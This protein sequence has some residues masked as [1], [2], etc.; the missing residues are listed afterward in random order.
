VT[1]SGEYDITVVDDSGIYITNSVVLNVSTAPCPFYSTNL[2]V[3]RVGDGAQA[4]SGATGNTI[5]LDQYTTSGTYVSSIQIPD[6]SLGAPYGSGSSASVYGSPALLLPGAG[7]DYINSGM[8]TLSGN[9]QF[10]TFAAYCENF[11]FHGPDVTTAANGGPYWRGLALVNAAGQYTLAYTNSGLYTGASSGDSTS[12]SNHSV[13]ACVTIDG[14]DFWTAGQAGSGGGV[15]CLDPNNTVYKNGTGI[16]AISTSSL[17]GTHMVQVFGTNLVYSDALATNGSGLY[18]CAG[19]PV[20][21]ANHFATAKVLLNEGGR[22]NDFAISPDGRTV[23]IADTRPYTNSS[24]HGGGI[25]RWDTN[26]AL[27][28][29]TF[30]YSLPVHGTNG[31]CALTASF[32]ADIA[33]WGSNVL[34]ATLFATDSNSVLSSVVDNGPSSTPTTI[35]NTSPFNQALHGVRFGPIA[36]PLPVISAVSSGNQITLIVRKGQAGVTFRVLST[37]N[38]SSP[39]W[40][41][42]ATNS[43][44]NNGTATNLFDIDPH[45]TQRFYR[46][47]QY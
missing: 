36:A 43:F 29:Y 35:L 11:P 24:T 22:P 18:I 13:R 4:L 1:D 20:P 25:Q 14:L 17:T 9:R 31:G 28:G 19:T 42:V 40:V 34:G 7:Y 37:T 23:Y 46:I 27:G 26:S 38:L 44:S 3:L 41:F 16:P 33:Q 30:S 32:P 21:A 15:K 47:K 39:D 6:E 5:Y 10:L 8:L 2:V 12:G 45:E